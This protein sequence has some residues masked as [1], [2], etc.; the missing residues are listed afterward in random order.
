M[1]LLSSAIKTHAAFAIAICFI[2][3][4]VVYCLLVLIYY[5]LVQYD[6][7][8]R[9]CV[10][11]RLGVIRVFADCSRCPLFPGSGRRLRTGSR[12]H[13]FNRERLPT[14]AILDPA[15]TLQGR[16]LVAAL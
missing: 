10:R 2:G 6:L 12:R 3:R 5:P 4:R 13:F 16:A 15:W 9:Q 14:D 11:S 7:L 1:S 8:P